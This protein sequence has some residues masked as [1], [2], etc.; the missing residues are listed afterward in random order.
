MRTTQ[1]R[2]RGG[3]I[4]I[5]LV[6]VETNLISSSSMAETARVSSQA[7]DQ[8][9]QQSEERILKLVLLGVSCF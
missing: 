3:Q 1:E 5:E 7:Q 2:A 9:R 6:R 4:E 8:E